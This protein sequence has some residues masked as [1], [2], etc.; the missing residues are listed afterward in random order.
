VVP[1]I[2]VQVIADQGTA[3]KNGLISIAPARIGGG[4]IFNCA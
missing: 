4:F 2:V 3:A 1:V